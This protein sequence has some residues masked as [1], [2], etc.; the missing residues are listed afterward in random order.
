[1]RET[2]PWVAPHSRLGALRL[3]EADVLACVTF[4]AE[5]ARE[6]HVD[7]PLEPAA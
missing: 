6:R 2:C 1:M 5:M 4:G 3:I 7:V